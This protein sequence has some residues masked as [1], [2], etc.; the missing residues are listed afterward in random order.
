MVWAI[1]NSNF[2]ISSFPKRIQVSHQN[3]R[4]R[5]LFMPYCGARLHKC[6][7]FGFVLMISAFDR[8]SMGADGS[9]F[10]PRRCVVWVYVECRTKCMVY[11]WWPTPRSPPSQCDRCNQSKRHCSLPWLCNDRSLICGSKNWLLLLKCSWQFHSK[12]WTIIKRWTLLRYVP[13]AMMD[14]N[15]T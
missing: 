10:I 4:E 11:N 12:G 2:G 13:I 9:V 3:E 6:S 15:S 14:D 1:N 5:K 8:H 7:T